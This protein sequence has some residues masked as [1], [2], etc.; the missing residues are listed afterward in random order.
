[1]EEKKKGEGL[2]VSLFLLTRRVFLKREEKEVGW[3]GLNRCG[4]FGGG[5]SRVKAW[6]LLDLIEVQQLL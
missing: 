3:S 2:G 4:L 5:R 6:L 1:L